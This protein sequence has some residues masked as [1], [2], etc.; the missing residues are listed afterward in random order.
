[1]VEKNVYQFFAIKQMEGG[2][3]PQKFL[4]LIFL[5]LLDCWSTSSSNQIKVAIVRCSSTL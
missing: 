2:T 1:M 3:V 5:L 4:Y